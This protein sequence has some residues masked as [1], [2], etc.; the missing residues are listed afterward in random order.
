MLQALINEN[1]YQIEVNNN[2]IILNG[3][4]F[5][6]DIARLNEHTYHVLSNHNSYTVEL[7]GIDKKEKLVTLK[8]NTT[9]YKVAI[10]DKMDLLLES[11]GIET[12][13]DKK[14]KSLQAPM[15]GLIIDI[16]I[17]EGQSI[18][19]GEKLVILEAMK[20]ENVIKAS[21]DVVVSK[22]HVAVEDSVENG[23]ILIEFE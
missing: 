23:Q 9:H 20:M 15:P 16:C 4:A 5:P 17:N 11:L 2:D 10:K 13:L 1:K 22:I 6:L 3:T 8:I 7:I 19:K 14:V 18:A 21:A 12:K